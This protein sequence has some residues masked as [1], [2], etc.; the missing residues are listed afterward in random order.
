MN[1]YQ[2]SLIKRHRRTRDQLDTILAGVI[3]IINGEAGRITIRHLFYRLV[4]LKLIE[5]TER[6]YSKLCSH[7]M[8]W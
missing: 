2:T 3:N 7:L 8:K 1:A 6:E 4:S 5:K